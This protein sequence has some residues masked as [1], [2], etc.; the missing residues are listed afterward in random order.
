MGLIAYLIF[1]FLIGGV[2]YAIGMVVASVAAI[3]TILFV[4]GFLVYCCIEWIKG[5]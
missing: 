5:R 2:I 4:I 3:L 1:I